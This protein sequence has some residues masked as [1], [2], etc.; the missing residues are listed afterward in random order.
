MDR[1]DES[2]PDPELKPD[3]GSESQTTDPNPPEEELEVTPQQW[4]MQNGV[5]LV[6][7]LGVVIY[8]V[9]NLQVMPFLIM[10]LG[11]GLVI[12]IHELGHFLAAKWCDV[13]VQ[14]FSI[15]F[16]PTIPG[17]SFVWGETT[18][19][20]AIIPLGGYVQ[21]VGQVDGSEESD[22]SE[23]D[24]RSY[25]NKT[26]LQRM[27]IISAGVIMN[28]FFAMLCFVLVFQIPGKYRQSSVI[29]GVDSGSP[30]FEAGIP[31]GDVI[32]KI[33]TLEN[34]YFE[35]IK[36]TV[37]TSG[38]EDK[39]P[40]QYKNPYTKE[41]KD[42]QIA[43]RKG[44]NDK[45]PVIG[46][47]MSKRLKFV[48]KK[49]KKLVNAPVYPYTVAAEAD[50]KFDDTI[51]GMTD[52]DADFKVTE[53]PFDPRKKATKKDGKQRD[54][55]KFNERL[56]TLA[57]MGKKDV[58]LRIERGDK[59]SK[60]T[61]DIKLKMPSHRTM[62]AVMGM[63]E[64]TTVRKNSPADKAK[65]Q[66]RHL[67][68]KADDETTDFHLKGDVIK[69][70]EVKN[71]KG[72]P[73]RFST[74]PDLFKNQVLC[75]QLAAYLKPTLARN[76]ILDE[77]EKDRKIEKW[78]D[79]MRLP[80]D[81]KKWAH[82]LAEANKL[83]ELGQVTLHM[84][85]HIPPTGPSY[86]YPV[87]KLRWDPNWKHHVCIPLNRYSPMAIPELGFGYQVTTGVVYVKPGNANKNQ[88][89]LIAGDIIKK[90]KFKELADFKKKETEESAWIELS[91]NPETEEEDDGNYPVQWAHV[92]SLLLQS[93]EIREVTLE[94]D[95]KNKEEPVIVK[96]VPEED[97]TWPSTNLGLFLDQDNRLEKADDF[98]DAIGMGLRDTHNRVLE[99]FLSIKS[100]VTGRISVDN[101]AGP[102]RIGKIAYTFAE[103]D[104]WEFVF[105]L[106]MISINLAVIN[107]LPIPVLDGGHM[108]FLLYELVRG[109]PA[110]EGVRNGATIVGL[111]FLASLMIFV[112]YLDFSR[113]FFA[114]G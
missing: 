17:C 108:V 31:T 57:I 93:P 39:L 65:V 88:K 34:P 3:D 67:R 78:L 56:Q 61:K 21:M 97:E 76:F 73:V 59:K 44:K 105:F 6:I 25:R 18:Y 43:T 91:A 92:S 114:S 52:P 58:T 83:E 110:S 10:M 2:R 72:Q 1:Q 11:L 104:F 19:K 75:Q 109:K 49:Y 48:D 26:V 96:L 94:V 79:P 101:L 37:M 36:I 12:F 82:Q 99:V 13:H 103:M 14:A 95:R 84:K 60:T 89:G 41:F 107:F 64:I 46:I 106:G 86:A 33:G 30:A 70:V 29:A 15:G 22:G 7:V 9:T 98:F 111:V 87:L 81:L 20:L 100:M 51:I 54:Y 8:V 102:L 28:V 24:P 62:G 85:R 55:F 47:V 32:T 38:S 74:T 45:S 63:G 90:V 4:L 53:L 35:D 80:F 71:E 66:K 23:D 68:P 113:M 5:L 77:V 42:L 40:L 69:T 27:L 16:G 50:F 112:I